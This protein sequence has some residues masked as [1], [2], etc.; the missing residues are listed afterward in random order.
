MSTVSVHFSFSGLLRIQVHL[1]PP[2]DDEFT[3]LEPLDATRVNAAGITCADTESLA[4]DR[5]WTNAR[6]ST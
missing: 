4:P 5:R 2:P 1:L 6:R 3:I